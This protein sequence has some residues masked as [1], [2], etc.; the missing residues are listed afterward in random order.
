MVLVRTSAQGRVKALCAID[1]NAR[2]PVPKSIADYEGEQIIY[3][4][5]RFERAKKPGTMTG[6]C[7]YMRDSSPF[8]LERDRSTGVS[9]SLEISDEFYQG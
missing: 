9:G 1:A 6:T 8:L 4:F 7:Q 2:T 3:K 5:D